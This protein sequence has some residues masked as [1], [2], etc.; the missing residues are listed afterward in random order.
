MKIN[1]KM[2]ECEKVIVFGQEC[3]YI[4]EYQIQIDI[5]NFY[6]VKDGIQTSMFGYIV[7]IK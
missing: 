6:P 1:V 7:T 2:S 3:F 4:P 5:R